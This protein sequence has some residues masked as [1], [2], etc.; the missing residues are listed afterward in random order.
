MAGCYPPLPLCED[1]YELPMLG[2]HVQLRISATT[3]SYSGHLRG[4]NGMSSGDR[5]ERSTQQRS[6]EFL[7][8]ASIGWCAVDSKIPC[9]MSLRRGSC[10]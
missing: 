4:P 10:S 2:L 9:F 1:F 8:P 7:L 3:K 5:D 6:P